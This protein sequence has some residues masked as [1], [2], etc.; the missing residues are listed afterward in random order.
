MRIIAGENRGR[1]L[2]APRGQNTRPTTDRVRESLM[3]ALESR[4]G[5]L[6]RAVVLDAF[7]GSGALAFEALSRGAE[8]A[9][10]CDCDREALKAVK[11][12]AI[13][14][15]Y[16]PQRALVKR[17]DVLKGA[18]PRLRLPYDVVFLDPPYA[19]GA[20]AVFGLLARLDAAGALSSDVL[21]VYEHAAADNQAVDEAQR[22][23]CLR[24]ASR[25]SY[26][27]TVVDILEPRLERDAKPGDEEENERGAGCE[28]AQWVA[29]GC[30]AR[31][32]ESEG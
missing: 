26:G 3:S 16:P 21:V 8:S 31:E 14:L 29:R 25:R 19:T 32:N 1:R 18:V 30:S 13:S 4:R 24:T 22:R 5:G 11:E 6:R 20:E 15:G 23:S 10:L 2:A 17:V 12:N 7:A 9:C 28:G 27:E